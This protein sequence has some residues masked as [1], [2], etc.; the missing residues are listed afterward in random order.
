MTQPTR[1]RGVWFLLALGVLFVVRIDVWNQHNSARLL[2]LP[3]SFT[4]HILFSLGLIAFFY[5]MVRFA[6]PY[7]DEPGD[8]S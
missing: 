7:P 8:E 6:W 4:Y 5:A 1:R 3:I 2:G